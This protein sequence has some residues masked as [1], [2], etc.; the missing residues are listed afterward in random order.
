LQ[1][2]LKSCKIITPKLYDMRSQTVGILARTID[3]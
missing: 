1:S 2:V 3:K